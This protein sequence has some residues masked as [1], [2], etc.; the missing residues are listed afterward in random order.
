C[1]G[2]ASSQRR[3]VGAPLRGRSRAVCGNRLRQRLAYARMRE[4][5]IIVDMRQGEPL[6]QAV[7]PRAECADPSPHRGH[8]LAHRQVEAV[9]VERR[10]AP[11]PAA[12]ERSMRLR[13]TPL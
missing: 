1:L 6:P 11:P 13:L 5:K 7:L 10:I 2:Q 12:S 8:M 3:W 9:T 4:A